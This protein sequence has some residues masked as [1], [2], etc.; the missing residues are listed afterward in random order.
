MP[1]VTTKGAMDASE[2]LKKNKMR[3]MQ[4]GDWANVLTVR[5]TDQKPVCKDCAGPYWGPIEEVK[6]AKKA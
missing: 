6:S 1:L 4:C 3:C 5:P 2:G